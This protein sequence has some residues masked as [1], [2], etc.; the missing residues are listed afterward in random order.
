[1]RRQKARQRGYRNKRLRDEQVAEQ[2]GVFDEYEDRFIL[3][4]LAET[5]LGQIV[6]A[7]YGRNNQKNLIEQSKNALSAY[8][9]PTGQLL[10]NEV[11]MVMAML[12]QFLI[13]VQLQDDATSAD[14][15]DDGGGADLVFEHSE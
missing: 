1:M 6:N 13:E 12:A 14:V 3:T 8:R 11:W 2:T 7:V 5:S 9:M 4:D 15:S 10:A